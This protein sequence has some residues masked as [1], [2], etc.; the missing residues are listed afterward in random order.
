MKVN[1]LT[2]AQKMILCGQIATLLGGLLISLGTLLSLSEPPSQPIFGSVGNGN[3]SIGG[4]NSA[5]QY[6]F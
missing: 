5:H 3:G 2:N 4:N 1:E 6:F